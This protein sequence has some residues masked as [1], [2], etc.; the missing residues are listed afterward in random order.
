MSIH[1]PSIGKYRVLRELGRGATGVVYLAHDSFRDL[2]VAVKV[3]HA[4]LLIDSAQSSKYRRMLQ[5]EA[6]LAGRLSHPHIV[7]M[8]D[9]DAQAHPPYLVLEFVD[10]KSLAAFS[11]PGTLLPIYD[12]INVVF[13]CCNALEYAQTQ[14]LVHRDIKP[15]NLMLQ[16][17]GEVKLMDFGTA[18]LIDGDAT[19]MAGL[20]GSPCYMSPEQ[21][22]EEKLTHHSDMFSLGVVLYELLTG[23]KPFQG[24]SDYATIYKIN[25]EEAT[26]MKVLRPEL[27]SLMDNVVSRALAK[28]PQDRFTSWREFAQALVAVNRSLPKLASQSMEAVRFQL[29]RDMPFFAEFSDVAI[30]ETL[31]LGKIHS[32]AAGGTLMQEGATGESFYILLEGTVVVT[33]KDCVLCNLRE[34]VSI[35]EMVYLQPEDNIRTATVKAQTDIIILKVQCTSLRKAT[36]EVQ[37]SFDK[38]FIRMLVT[39]LIATNRQLAE[40]DI[41]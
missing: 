5:H 24:D 28:R 3:I 35:G 25:T 8:V 41:V 39:R 15:A 36:A 13:K 9:I 27:P 37:A 4:H 34:G 1:P 21:V 33:R 29:L 31:R 14:G 32:L 38:A 11:N 17:D 18:L 16:A 30:W 2:Q 10:G 6:V 40:W 12:V 26:P 20:V 19:Q 7:G 23:H 22:R